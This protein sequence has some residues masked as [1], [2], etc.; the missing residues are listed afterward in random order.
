MGGQVCICS[1]SMGHNGFK[2]GIIMEL[3]QVM[4][5][6]SFVVI[7]DTLDENKFAYKIKNAMLE[8]GYQV[9]CVGSELQSINDV[10]GEID[11]LD[12]CIRADR[13]L[14]LLKECKKDFKSIVIQPGA[15]SEEL[16]NYLND[17]QIPY[18]DGCLLV[19]LDKYV[20]KS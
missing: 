15:S 2:K 20:K 10:T 16:V 4:E 11:I 7:G 18:I 8:H 12:L 17:N 9:E 14:S 6:K 13:G 3:K 1:S 19:G 5:Q